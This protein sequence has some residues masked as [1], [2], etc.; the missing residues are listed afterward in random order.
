MEEEEILN[1][2]DGYKKAVETLKSKGVSDLHL[3]RHIF[4]T[5][6]RLDWDLYNLKMSWTI[7]V[8]NEIIKNSLADIL[9]GDYQYKIILAKDLNGT[10]PLE[11][12]IDDSAFPSE[13]ARKKDFVLDKFNSTDISFEKVKE[14]RFDIWL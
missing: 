5:I 6:M 9:S 14:G 8:V 7:K 12:F 1:Q 3:S 2:I 11:T 4:S 13:W 10:V